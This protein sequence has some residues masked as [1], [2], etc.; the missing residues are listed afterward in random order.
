MANLAKLNP[1]PGVGDIGFLQ[2]H[3]VVET[4]LFSSFLSHCIGN[5]VLDVS[6]RRF[7]VFCVHAPTAVDYHGTE[8]C[9]FYDELSTLLNDI[10]LRDLMLICGNL[11]VPSTA[12]G[13]RM[14]NACRELNCNTKTLQEF[15]NLHDLIAANDIMRQKR[16]N[17]PTFDGPIGR[18]THI[19][20]KFGRNRF[21]LCVIR[22]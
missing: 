22:S 18:C 19:Y 7:H 11:N 12:D 6:E 14:K 21:R 2:S 3:P 10:P 15:I 5:V 4:Q 13:C 17:L 1:F 8:Y 16:S 9:T 20:W